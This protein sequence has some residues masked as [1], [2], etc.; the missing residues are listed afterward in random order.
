[1]ATEDDHL[2]LRELLPWYANGTLAPAE[3]VPLRE[4]LAGCA[5]CRGELAQWA[6]IGSKLQTRDEAGWQPSAAHWSR[7]LA[8]VDAAEAHDVPPQRRDAF[9]RLRAWLAGSPRSV[10]YALAAQT[11]LI[12][13]LGVVVAATMQAPRYETLSAGQAKPAGRTAALRV[14]FGNDITEREARELLLAIRGQIVQG[15]SAL[16]LY[17]IEVP[18]Q[19]AGS[20]IARLRAH[21][22]VR[23]AEPLDAPERP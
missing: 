11:V 4:H 19:D 22:Q 7:V 8:T 5:G 6:Q 20:A 2:R 18:A 12:A 23:L 3:A 21:R 15:P 10:R 13:A 17:T 14:A 1:M 16:G 9:A